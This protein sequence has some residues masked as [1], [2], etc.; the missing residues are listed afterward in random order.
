MRIAHRLLPLVF[1]SALPLGPRAMA[2]PALATPE[3]AATP[4]RSLS[5][6]ILVGQH[7]F[8]AS[9]DEGAADA[10]GAALKLAPT[11]DELR[12]QAFVASLLAARPDAE[13][14]AQSLPDNALAELLTA[15]AR[16][17]AGDWP[18]AVAAF[19]ALPP[20]REGSPQQGFVTLLQPLLVAWAEAG[21]G[22]TDAALGMLRPLIEGGQG[23]AIFALHGALMADIAG[24]NDEAG[25][26][27]R[28]ASA[29]FDGVNLRVAQILASWQARSGHPADAER[30]LR[31]LRLSANELS[32][33]IPAI[34]ASIKTRPVANAADG[35]ADV[36]LALAAAVR[37]Q[38][39][40]DVSLA[41]LRLALDL[42]PD[43]TAARLLMSQMQA[44]SGH[45]EAAL[46]TLEPVRDTDPLY[47]AIA[48]HR[49]SLMAQSDKKDAAIQLFEQVARAYP[50]SPLPYSQLGDLYED[51]KRYPD[52]VTAYDKAVSRLAPVEGAADTA[53]DRPYWALFYARGIAEERS[54]HWPRA[55]ADFRLAL[56]LSP[57]Q[58]FVLN[59]L[60]YT[61]ADRGVHL[62]EARAMLE[63]AAQQEPNDG[64]I[65][66]S[67]GWVLLR[68]GNTADAVRTLERATE[69]EPEDSSINGHLG[70]AYAAAGRLR[71]AGFQWQ[72]A[73]S[74]NPSPDD[75]AALRRKLAEIEAAAPK[76]PSG[77]ASTAGP[78]TDTPGIVAR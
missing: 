34:A 70:D 47:G 71:E 37:G 9:D 55:E 20:M 59:Y 66:D 78:H 48:L 25:V 61:W 52:A 63:R 36:Y 72:R 68:Q 65:T 5:G 19:R 51:T 1:L 32:I 42:R 41:L 75:A 35:I 53:A 13:A 43:F 74:L 15:G 73:L 29:D 14:L 27:Y 21:A 76:P 30:T 16:V 18:G 49:A 77:S 57:D 67:L 2:A 39:S 64:A 54:H 56:K 7:A 31:A 58:P 69:M 50:Q 8:G 24:R 60:G 3:P 11:L 44:A 17:R 40:F 38:E 46:A 45:P 4:D 28:R 26:M 22:N 6:L 33:A 23:T 62:V 12:E 10:L